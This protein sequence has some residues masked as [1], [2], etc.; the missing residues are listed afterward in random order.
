MNSLR[1]TTLA[2][3][4]GVSALA[5]LAVPTFASGDHDAE[6]A[7]SVQV[8][9][10]GQGY[11]GWGG[12]GGMM[13]PGMMGR[14]MMGYG[15]APFVPGAEADTH[16]PYAA[17]SAVDKDLSA[18]DV[19]ASLEHSLTMHGNKRLKVGE[20]KEADEE[21]FVAE[22]VTVDDSLVQRMEIDRHTGTM[23]RVE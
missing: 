21:T 15:M 23:R 10:M 16:C 9:H 19:R 18:D 20:V 8:A 22:I 17:T 12:R 5:F 14:G 4:A 6:G 7:G 1:K 13:G 3:I 2:A 11:G